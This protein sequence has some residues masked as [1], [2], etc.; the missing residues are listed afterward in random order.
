MAEAKEPEAWEVIAGEIA[1]GST[2][3][4]E[5]FRWHEHYCHDESSTWTAFTEATGITRRDHAESI[6]P[7]LVR[8][9]AQKK[10]GLRVLVA[11]EF[12]DCERVCFSV[13]P[14]DFSKQ[15]EYSA[16]D[17][18]TAALAAIRALEEGE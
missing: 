17:I 7:R 12:Y 1:P 14:D 5:R 16:P 2:V 9:A 4:M 6:A 13:T 11:V 15:S 3:D 18:C 10:H 8:E